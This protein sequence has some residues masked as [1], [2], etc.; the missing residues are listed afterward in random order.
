MTAGRGPT[1]SAVARPGL[2]P[3][4]KGV[5][6]LFAML[7]LAQAALA[8]NGW[9]LNRDLIDVH[10]LVGGALVVAAAVQAV[11]V[12]LV[13]ASADVRGQLRFVAA[14][15]LVLVA[16]QYVLG[17]AGRESGQAA[18]WHVPNGVLIFGLS[19]VNAAMVVRLGR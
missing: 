13:G 3:I 19:T 17:F 18:A 12:F 9:F 6:G 11:L 5:A 15:I 2:L 4:L 10:G 16:A 1:G 14:S 8:G 7:V